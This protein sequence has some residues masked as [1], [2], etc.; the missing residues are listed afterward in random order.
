M[1]AT[2]ASA[3]IVVD[4]VE[5]AYDLALPDAADAP[6]VV[7]LP[8]MGDL[9]SAYRHL[10]PLLTDR[11]VRVAALD[12]PGHGDSGISPAPVGQ[13]QIAR[14][15]VALVEQLGGPAIVVGHSFTPDSALL[16]TQLA[17]EEVVG[18]VAI[19]PWATTPEQPWA[20]R[21][22]SRVVASTPWMWS[23]FYRSLHKA[24]PS[25]L[26]EH[27]RRIV[28]SLRRPRGTEAVATMAAGTT[29]DAIGARAGQL[30]PVAVVMG[31]ADPDF[32][33]PAA[34]AQ[35]YADA[36]AGTA[37][38]TVRMIDGAGHYPHAERP[39]ETA[40]AVLELARGLGWSVER[41]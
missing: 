29:K 7:L 31:G 23:L 13:R 12:L 34:E 17:P 32:R 36:V 4:D 25:D 41:A 35:D 22:L 16:A 24:P 10:T 1:N 40:D 30:A 38:V 6:L 19:A 39:D 9:R 15:A 26:A 21:T 5:L 20:M 28:A 11:G 37:P 8:G 2:T 3:R 33:E 27:R 18:A 14:A